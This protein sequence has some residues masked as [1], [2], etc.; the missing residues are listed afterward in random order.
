MPYIIH[1]DI[2]YKKGQAV[3]W[4]FV[5]YNSSSNLTLEESAIAANKFNDFV[6]AKSKASNEVVKNFDKAHKTII[7]PTALRINP[8]L[9]PPS[10]D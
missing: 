7:K 5:I 10:F 9:H 2:K 4:P 1:H 3:A 6:V 8:V